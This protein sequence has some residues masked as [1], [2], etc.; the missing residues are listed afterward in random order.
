MTRLAE[1]EVATSQIAAARAG[2]RFAAAAL[3]DLLA[4]PAYTLARR[5]TG[6]DAAEDVFQDSMMQV[7]EKLDSYRGAAPFGC[8]VRSIVVNRSLQLLRSPWHRARRLLDTE[9]EIEDLTASGADVAAAMDAETMLSRLAPVP[10]AVLWL[11][12][13]EGLSHA[14]IAARFGRSESFSKSQLARA[15]ARLRCEQAVPL[16]GQVKV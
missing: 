2:D 1:L 5:L 13:V 8:W 12:A 7:F 11:H 3:Y 10:R 16:P 14:E 4:G 15:L 9:S 6:A